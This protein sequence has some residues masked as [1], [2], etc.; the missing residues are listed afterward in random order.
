MKRYSSSVTHDSSPSRAL[1]SGFRLVAA[2][3]A[4]RLLAPF[5]QPDWRARPP[6]R[7]GRAPFPGSALELDGAWYEILAFESAPPP[8]RGVVY[9]LAPWDER[10]PLRRTFSL[11]PEALEKAAR[12]ERDRQ[13]NQRKAEALGALPFLLGLLPAEDQLELERQ[14]NINGSRNTFWTA[15][16]M[17][18]SSVFLIMVSFAYNQGMAFG[19]LT[20]WVSQFAPWVPIY[21]Y[22]VLESAGR[23]AQSMGG[24]PMGS[25]PVALPVLLVRAIAQALSPEARRRAAVA[26]EFRSTPRSFEN[27]RDE[28]RFL[29]GDRLE[30]LSRLPKKHWTVNLTG[31]RYGDQYY[32]VDDRQVLE[33][34]KGLR[35]RFVLKVPETEILF[36]DVYDYD[37]TEVREVYRE[38]RRLDAAMWVE[39]FSFL[40]GFLD[41]TTQ[42]RIEKSYDYEPWNKTRWSTTLATLVALWWILDGVSAAQTGRATLTDGLAFLAALYMLWECWMRRRALGEG[43]IRGSVLRWVLKPLVLPALVWGPKPASMQLPTMER[44]DGEIDEVFE[45]EP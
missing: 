11:A 32:Y 28:V 25:L 15:A 35:H 37:P 24:Q 44:A 31:V 12:K 38:E 26:R 42:V 4:L 27:A 8:G 30:I 34:K 33:T 13:K 23:L 1:G 18:A 20:P 19:N 36:K 10:F 45:P 6:E 40:W 39:T 41:Q 7:L 43:E 3:S 14:Y 29:K 22:F 2:D 16:I 9:H 21:V 17:L 5:L